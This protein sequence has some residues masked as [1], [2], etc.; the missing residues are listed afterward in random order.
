MIPDN[1]YIIKPKKVKP[2]ALQEFDNPLHKLIPN[3]KLV[4]I[5]KILE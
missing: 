3:L 1:A 5:D 2:T 4:D